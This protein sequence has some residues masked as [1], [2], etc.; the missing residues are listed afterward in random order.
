MYLNTTGLKEWSVRNWATQSKSGVITNQTTKVRSRPS[1]TDIHQEDREF[2]A[3][4]LI[5]CILKKHLKQSLMYIIS[6]KS[7]AKNLKKKYVINKF[8]EET[9]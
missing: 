5:S 3:N 9:R 8:Y 4:Q 7:N 1:R 2:M 6:T